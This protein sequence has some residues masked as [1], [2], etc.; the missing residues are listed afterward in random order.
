L[1]KKISDLELDAKGTK[2]K[3]S[4][5]IGIASTSQCSDLTDFLSSAENSLFQAKNMGGNM[6]IES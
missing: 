2:F 6:V 4:L 3:L 5:S 1:R